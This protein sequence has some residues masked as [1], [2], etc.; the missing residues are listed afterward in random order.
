MPDLRVLLEN[1]AIV[2]TPRVV[3]GVVRVALGPICQRAG[4]NLRLVETGSADLALYFDPGG[5]SATPCRLLIFGNCGG[6][7]IWVGACQ[8]LRVC[9]ENS[10]T[11]LQHV[12]SPGEVAFGR[13]VGNVAVHELGHMIASLSHSSYRHNFMYTGYPFPRNLR[14]RENLR[15][16]WA[17]RFSFD[18]RQ[19]DS[20]ALA[21]R[22]NTFSGTM[23]VAYVP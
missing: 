1:L 17:G 5:Q 10:Q 9:S 23:E 6:G 14:T 4:R 2:R 15:R 12:F 16:H 8:D 7:D 13:F 20:L 11:H 18:T 22:T 3:E 19:I 21:I